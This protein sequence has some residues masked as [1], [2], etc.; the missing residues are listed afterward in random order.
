MP[1]D[2]ARRSHAVFVRAV[3]LD[4]LRRAAFVDEAC[5]G[6]PALYERVR[7]LVAA[8]DTSAGFL[9]APALGGGDRR[10]APATVTVRG[11]QIVRVVGL[12]GMATVF[13]AIQEQP[14]RRVA[15]KV[16][17][18]AL[19]H[20]SAIRRFRYETEILARLQHPGIAQ[21]FEAGTCDDG[22][23][24]PVP[25]FAME[26]I[27]NAR[28]VTEY[29]AARPL[30]DRLALF[31]DVCD[32]V[33]H[34][35][36]HGVIH[37]DLKPGNILVDPA[38]R[39]RVIDFGVAR[40]ADPEAGGITRRADLGQLIGTLN[41]MSPEQCAGAEAIDVRA[42]V[43]SLGVILYTLVAGRPP[44]DFAKTPIPEAVRI[45]T[46]GAPARL[47]AVAPE[48]GGDLDAIVTTAMDRD[49]ARR[50]ISAGA[51][52]ADVRRYLRHQTIE[53]RPP[54]ALHQLRLFVRRHLV[55]VGAAAAVVVVLITACILVGLFAYRT[56]LEAKRRSTAELHA[57]AERDAARRQAYIANMAGGFGAL[58]THEF[59]QLRTRLAA[60]PEE[61]RGWEWSFLAGVAEPSERTVRAHNDM[62]YS[63]AAS[64]DG[65]RLATGARD[66]GLAIWDAAGTTTIARTDGLPEVPV[67]AVAFSPDGARVV[68]GAEDG[69]V[70]IWE[71]GAMTLVRELGRHETRVM[72]TSWSAG[73]AVASASEEGRARL[74]NPETGESRRIEQ[75]GG[76]IGVLFSEDG[77]QL[78]TWNRRGDVWLRSADAEA[79][80]QRWSLEGEPWCAAIR[81]SMVAAGGGAG[82]VMVWDA[83]TG[84]TLHDLATPVSA[85]IVRSLAFS[86]GGDRLAAGQIQRGI[87]LWSVPDGRRLGEIRGHDEAVSGVWFSPDDQKLVSASWDRT[88]RVWDIDAAASGLATTLTGHEDQVLITVFSPDAG[89]I[90]SA[91]RDRTIRLWE[92]GLGLS[93]GV[94]KGHRGDV[95]ALAFSP[96]GRTLASGALDRTVRLWDTRTGVPLPTIEAVSMVWT[97]AFSPDGRLLASAGEDGIVRLWNAQTR[98]LVRE[99]DRHDERVIRVAFSPDSRLLASASRDHSARLYEV[100]TGRVLHTLAEHEADVFAL[101]FSHD[102][103][104]LYT[105]SRDQ[106]VRVWDTASGARTD[107]LRGHGQFVTSLA[108]NPDGTRL[109]AGSWYGEIVL[110]DT[111]DHE[112]VGW[113]NG[114]DQA[115]RSVAFDPRGRW[116]ISA[117]YDRT[118]RLFDSLPPEQRRARRIEAQ[119]RYDA[120]RLVLD[121]LG[122]AYPTTQELVEAVESGDGFD[123]QMRVWLRTLI[124]MKSLQPVEQ[125]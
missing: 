92:P 32:G 38:G 33:Q 123:D 5:A 39:A 60:A 122:A 81:G 113:F 2:L 72:S 62:I 54:S 95:Y 40:S 31:S 57:I 110:W 23:G 4:P 43:Y 94:L 98:E 55:L 114:H 37:R 68:S 109:A 69:A 24:H 7:T 77:Q 20:T 87:V 85:S 79:I 16:M 67:F 56:A 124:L 65:T 117:S 12:G 36:M 42:D 22:H 82:R 97:V 15:L 84:A 73:G 17:S 52:A 35:H 50:Y 76:V 91:G 116:L 125:P 89:L 44:Y 27:E 64:P 6:D 49:P 83:R 108:L 102:G 48:A 34:G 105:G 11:Y 88:V 51:L 21:I 107:I 63:F 66:G 19:V 115:V 100:D 104:R 120:A 78:L 74:W 8:L 53:A 99:L 121:R 47:G 70:R 18:R 25:Y 118:I 119:D 26:F 71:A 106:T 96:D 75:P 61:Q 93:L 112:I 86:H 30:R 46:Q 45:I 13:E 3:E 1:D 90:A 103:R 29:A 101:A 14:R 10:A 9:E 80:H 111:R 58:R 59:L 41:S 28:T